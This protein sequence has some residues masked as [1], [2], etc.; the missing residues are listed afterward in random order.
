MDKN[1]SGQKGE[2]GN[3]TPLVQPQ[4]SSLAY[5]GKLMSLEIV[6]WTE[7]STYLVL[8]PDD[9]DWGCWPKSLLVVEISRKV[10]PAVSR[11]AGKAGPKKGT[12]RGIED[13]EARKNGVV[14]ERRRLVSGVVV[15]A[16][17]HSSSSSRDRLVD[18]LSWGWGSVSE[19]SVPPSSIASLTSKSGGG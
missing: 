12:I 6:G 18:R 13:T 1:K 9:T 4:M 3:V 14:Y 7:G 5:D 8:F 17:S 11:S 10:M 15:A 2:V 19:T 16:I